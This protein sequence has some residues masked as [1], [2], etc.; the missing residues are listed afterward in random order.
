MLDNAGNN[1]PAGMHT[2]EDCQV[3]RFGTAAYKHDLASIAVQ[4]SG[5]L[6]PRNFKPLLG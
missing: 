6:A 2:S 4:Q 5:K 3:I 1:V